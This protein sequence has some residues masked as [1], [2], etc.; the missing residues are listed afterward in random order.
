[1]SGLDL[2]FR[3]ALHRMAENA[4]YSGAFDL[5]FADP[6]F[7]E[8]REFEDLANRVDI[9]ARLLHNVGELSEA[10]HSQRC[11]FVVVQHPR[12]MPFTLPAPF[13]LWKSRRAGESFLSF[14]EWSSQAISAQ[15][16]QNIESMPVGA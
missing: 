15:V 6:P 4:E 5:V 2:R 12:R 14:F 3:T 9:L 16:T 13:A 7:S 8:P 10:A 1:M 11:R